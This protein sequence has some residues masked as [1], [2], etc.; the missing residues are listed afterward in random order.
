MTKEW[1]G[2][3]TTKV[4]DS[5]VDKKSL[6]R[7]M[8]KLRALPKAATKGITAEIAAGALLIRGDAQQ[9]MKTTS[10][11]EAKTRSRDGMTVTHAASAPGSPPAIDTGKLVGSVTHKISADG[12]DAAIGTNTA[13]GA[14]LEF[15]TKKMAAR[16]WLFPAFERNRKGIVK[17]IAKAVDVAN[18]EV[19]K[20]K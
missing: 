6:R 11:G 16:P 5:G 3:G 14:H 1:T 17:R 10:R 2:L 7:L 20:G 18:K 8:A 15:G 4:G 13:Y 12:L 19:A 9:S